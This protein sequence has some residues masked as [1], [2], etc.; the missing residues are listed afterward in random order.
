DIGRGEGIEVNAAFRT[1]DA[2]GR[3]LLVFE[4]FSHSFDWFSST[5]GVIPL[6][7]R[8]EIRPD[9]ERISKV[10]DISAEYRRGQQFGVLTA[11]VSRESLWTAALKI[12]ESHPFGVGPDN[13][14]LEYGKY[15]GVT[16]WDTRIYSN[17]LYLEIL[18]GSGI[19][20]LTSF[21]L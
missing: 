8:T 4:L 16:R 12:F 20:G 11:K 15:L 18:T 19:L 21:L 6:L 7:I 9:V 2:P 14:R 13:Y 10:S 3:Y 17:N 5:K 1:P